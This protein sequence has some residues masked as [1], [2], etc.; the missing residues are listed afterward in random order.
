LFY[1]R[2]ELLA[3]LREEPALEFV[4]RELREEKSAEPLVEGES[5]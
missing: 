3:L 1:A 5:T 2:R 4:A